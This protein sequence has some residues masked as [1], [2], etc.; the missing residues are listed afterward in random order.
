M[1]RAPRV[2]AGILLLLLA[3]CGARVPPPCPQVAVVSG[4]DRILVGGDGTAERLHHRGGLELRAVSCAYEAGGAV[5]DLSVDVAAEPGPAFTGG[6][7][8]LDY[9]V[10]VVAPDETVRDKSLLTTTIPLE[11][12]AGRAGFSETL[13]QRLPGVTAAE[14]PGW[15]LLLGIQPEAAPGQPGG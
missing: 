10:A 5:V 3:G 14:G 15:R 1:T 6:A 7:V 9:F 11:R 13:R 2:L 4:L 8:D 12:G